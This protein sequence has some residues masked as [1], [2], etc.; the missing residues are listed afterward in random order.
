MVSLNRNPKDRANKSDLNVLAQTQ[1]PQVMAPIMVDIRQLVTKQAS[2]PG[3]NNSVSSDN[4][5]ITTFWLSFDTEKL[6]AMQAQVLQGR[7]QSNIVSPHSMELAKVEVPTRPVKRQVAEAWNRQGNKRSRGTP[8]LEKERQ[9]K[10]IKT[11]G[12]CQCCEHYGRPCLQKEDNLMTVEARQHYHSDINRKLSMQDLDLEG[13][14]Q[15]LTI[16]LEDWTISFKEFQ[17]KRSKQSKKPVS[18]A[19]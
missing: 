11:P 18:K 15:N 17:L 1:R 14:A 5:Q 4:H 13:I 10:D 7:M 6:L 19:S 2:S 8:E 16:N 12:I 9:H 3:N